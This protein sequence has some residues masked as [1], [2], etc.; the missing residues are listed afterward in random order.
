MADF[1]DYMR[2]QTIGLNDD[3]TT[4]IYDCDIDRFISGHCRADTPTLD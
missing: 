3:G 4:D 1:W 2:G